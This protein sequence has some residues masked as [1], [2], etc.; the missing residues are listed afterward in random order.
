MNR[1]HD[2]VRPHLRHLKPYSSARDEFS[3]EARIFLDANENPFPSPYNRYPD[4]HQQRLRQKLSALKGVQ[5]NQLFLGNGS[6][7]A[8]DLLLRIYCEP[9]R[10]R[11]IIPQPTYGMYGVSAAINGIDVIP[12]PLTRDFDLDTTTVREAFSSAAKMLFLC[13]PNNPSGNLLNREK[14]AALIE[15]FPGIVVVDEAYIDFAESESWVTKLND[16]PN[17]VVLQ[18]LSK[19]WGLAGIRLGMAFASADIIAW[20][21]RIKPPYNISTAAQEIALA[22]ISKGFPHEQVELL[23]QQRNELRSALACLA[24]TEQIFPSDANFVLVRVKDADSLYQRLL[25]RGVVVRNR[26]N[27]MW[28]ENCLRITVGTPAENQHLIEQLKAV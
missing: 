11:V 15:A 10:D 22:S 5:P 26:S 4:P 8:I 3:G 7:E 27:V 6:D 24:I 19:A 13:S 9:G 25:E 2:L 23:K 1:I 18:T 16:L 20:L 28:C 17:L 21:N 14:V 12:V